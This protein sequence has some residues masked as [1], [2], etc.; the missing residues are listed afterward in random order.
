MDILLIWV[1]RILV[2]FSFFFYFVR[3]ATERFL[4]FEGNE[5]RGRE[6][7]HAPSGSKE[8]EEDRFLAWAQFR[9][10]WDRVGNVII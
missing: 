6:G 1:T 8:I 5:G 4:P 7:R 10:S 2:N 3:L 9:E